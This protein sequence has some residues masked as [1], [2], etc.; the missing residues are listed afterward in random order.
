MHAL[1]HQTILLGKV[2][3]TAECTAIIDRVLEEELHS[4]I[5]HRQFSIVNNSLEHEIGL[6]QLVVEEEI[7]MRK[8]HGK[9]VV[10]SLG[11]I[12]TQHIQ[13]G[14]HPATART[15]LVLNALLERFITEIGVQCTLMSMVTGQI[16]DVVRSKGIRQSTFGRG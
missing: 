12:T 16:I 3:H 7:S 14:K 2:S 4:G 6:L 5:F 13:A 10:V 15:L 11:K 1:G 8:L 9:R